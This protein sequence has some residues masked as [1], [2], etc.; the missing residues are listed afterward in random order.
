MSPCPQCF[1]IWLSLNAALEQKQGGF[2]RAPFRNLC[3]V[4]NTTYS[5][6]VDVVAWPVERVAP[7]NRYHWLK[8]VS[9]HIHTMVQV[10]SK[11]L[12][13]LCCLD[14]LVKMCKSCAQLLS[15][16]NVV[17]QF[18][19]YDNIFRHHWNCY[20]YFFRVIIFPKPPATC[21]LSEISLERCNTSAAMYFCF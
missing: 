6:E 4:M 3:S 14:A 12:K 2:S 11:F 7:V 21:I 13:L 17:W 19:A 20:G 1:D 18:K 16:L 15:Q 9:T 10:R 5:V 8:G